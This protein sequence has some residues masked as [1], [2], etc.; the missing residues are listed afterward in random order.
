MAIAYEESI[1]IIT[2]RRNSFFIGLPFYRGALFEDKS[3]CDE[4]QEIRF[5]K[6]RIMVYRPE[7][8]K[9]YKASAVINS[10]IFVVLFPFQETSEKADTRDGF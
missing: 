6:S 7:T 2:K 1:P 8:A 5:G 3:N 4:C 9:T 10:F